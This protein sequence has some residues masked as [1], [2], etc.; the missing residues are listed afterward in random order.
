MSLAVDLTGQRFNLLTVTHPTNESSKRGRLWHCNCDCGRT[1]IVVTR[2]LISGHV[3]SCGCQR[4]KA[5]HLKT[6]AIERT[7]P[8]R[9]P[10]G[11]LAREPGDELLNARAACKKCGL[12][13]GAFFARQS[14][15]WA[16]LKGKSLTPHTRHW[17]LPGENPRRP[18]QT[19]L[20]SELRKAMET[21]YGQT[22]TDQKGRLGRNLVSAVGQYPNLY[23]QLICEARKK[24]TRLLLNKSG[25]PRHLKGF[26]G[27]NPESGKRIRYDLDL[28]LKEM[29]DRLKEQP[30][31]TAIER[32]KRRRLVG[33]AFYENELGRW[34]T[35]PQ[36]QRVRGTPNGWCYVWS[37][38]D[39]KKRVRSRLRPGQD[40][41]RSK[42]IASPP[43]HEGP[44]T[45]RVFLEPDGL[46][47]LNGKES[48]RPGAGRGIV[49]QRLRDKKRQAARS[50]LLQ[51]IPRDCGLPASRVLNEAR[52]NY[53]LSRRQVEMA[54]EALGGTKG[55]NGHY[56]LWR[57]PP[58]A[59]PATTNGH[60]EVP[61]PLG[62]GEHLSPPKRR[63][64]R[65]KG[66]IDPS[67][68]QRNAQIR[69]AWAGGQYEKVAHLA[70]AFQVDPSYAG[71]LVRGISKK[72]PGK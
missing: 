22:R 63:P 20:L 3:K 61:L 45:V 62:N 47:I 51:I 34:L 19:F 39:S 57:L 41:L 29:S 64:G 46:A 32:S 60:T 18:E 24:P 31:S 33:P 26:K 27:L 69:S 36:W 48:E 23:P 14:N 1:I 11:D 44:G 68:I 72:K 17:A 12:K 70:K 50:A 40:A 21:G 43:G 56:R 13:L 52:A 37:P 5:E 6:F 66:S 71:K 9:Y 15:G 65:P 28:D 42:T 59:Y 4:A 30:E 67:V 58:S 55:R 35:D 10:A 53:G 7:K 25:K 49:A 54:F 8:R 2:D 38:A 16:S